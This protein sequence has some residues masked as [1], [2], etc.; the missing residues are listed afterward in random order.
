[1]PLA[2]PNSFSLVSNEAG[3]SF[4][5][6]IATGSPRSK[7]TLITVALSGASSGLMVR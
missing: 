6:S 4:A 2:L 5:P 3:D 7:S 1:M